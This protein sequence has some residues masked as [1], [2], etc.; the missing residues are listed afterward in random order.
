METEKRFAALVAEFA[1]HPDVEVPGESSRR[2]FGSEALKVKGSI[3]AMLTGGRLVVKLPRHRVDALIE[4]GTGASFYSGKGQPM[5][6][7]VAV[8][9]DDPDTWTALAGEALD[10]VSSRS[11]PR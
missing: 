8:A 2:R 4:S 6:E 5:K 11:G 9:T 3:F 1:G 7:W 10:F